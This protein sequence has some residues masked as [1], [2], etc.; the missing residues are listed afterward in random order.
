MR[1]SDEVK[2]F[3]RTG[4]RLFQGRFLRYMEGPKHKGQI[5]CDETTQGY[6]DPQKAKINF[7]VPDRRVLKVEHK[8]VEGH[9]FQTE[10]S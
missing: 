2:C 7:I 3:W 1:Y 6:F 5:V 8:M 10:G 4:L 9:L